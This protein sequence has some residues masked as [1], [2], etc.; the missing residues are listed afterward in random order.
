MESKIELFI[1][2]LDKLTE[3]VEALERRLEKMGYGKKDG[4]FTAIKE[5][6]ESLRSDVEDE[7]DELQDR[8]DYLE[9]NL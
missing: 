8:L 1:A 2:T 5:D 7:L 3:R 9:S 4:E 6:I